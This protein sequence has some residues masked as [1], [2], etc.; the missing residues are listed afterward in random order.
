MGS[1]GGVNVRGHS[2]EI[3]TDQPVDPAELVVELLVCLG[4]GECTGGRLEHLHQDGHDDH[5]HGDGHQHLD[6]GHA[7]AGAAWFELGQVVRFT[8][9]TPSAG[10]NVEATYRVKM[11]WGSR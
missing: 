9:E 4:R 6:Q 7:A 2:F 11:V 3:G 5:Q 1:S 10:K 8:V